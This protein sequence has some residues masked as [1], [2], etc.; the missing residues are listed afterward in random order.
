[1][2]LAFKKHCKLYCRASLSWLEGTARYTTSPLLHVRHPL[3]CG[4]L[5]FVSSQRPACCF[6]TPECVVHRK[7]PV[8]IHHYLIVRI[9]QTP[10]GRYFIGSGGTH[11]PGITYTVAQ[12]L[13][14]SLPDLPAQYVQS[15]VSDAGP[16]NILLPELIEQMQPHQMLAGK[17]PLFRVQLTEIQ[18]GCVLGI[19]FSHALAGAD[20]PL[21]LVWLCH[22]A[23]NCCQAES[24][25][26]TVAVKQIARSG[27]MFIDMSHAFPRIDVM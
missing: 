25:D 13:S 20:W 23:K 4:F 24:V 7:A 16:V 19:S 2:Q 14:L 22:S 10:E 21:S 15:R 6:S 9:C 8:P 5:A 27:S 26:M 17:E 11:P 18:D 1:M 12:K 3:L